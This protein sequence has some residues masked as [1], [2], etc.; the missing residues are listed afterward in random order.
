MTGTTAKPASRVRTFLAERW[1]SILLVVVVL[2]FVVQNRNPV[3]ITIFA[4]T[5]SSPLW[6]TLT[7]TFVLGLAAGIIRTRR[8]G[9]AKG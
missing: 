1:L 4:V 2:L 5:I 8:R 3:D 9:S 7:I 6:L